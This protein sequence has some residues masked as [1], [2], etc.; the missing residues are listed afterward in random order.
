MLHTRHAVTTMHVVIGVVPALVAK[1]GQTHT[2]DSERNISV[3][4]WQAWIRGFFTDGQEP[5]PK[6]NK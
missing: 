2:N 3:F 4:L 5:T 6:G 1:G